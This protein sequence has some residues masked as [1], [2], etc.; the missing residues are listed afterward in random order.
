HLAHDLGQPGRVEALAQVDG[1]DVAVDVDGVD[2]AGG[3]ELAGQRR[4]RGHTVGVGDRVEPLVAHSGQGAVEL[5]PHHPG[6]GAR[7]LD[8]SDQLAHDGGHA[9][10]SAPSAPTA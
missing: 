1:D 5:E 10:A 4:R 2:L 6:G 8:D 7:L 9:S 3:E